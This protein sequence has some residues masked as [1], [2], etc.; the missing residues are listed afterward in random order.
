VCHCRE[1]LQGHIRHGG[2]CH[3]AAQK[4]YWARHACLQVQSPTV[5]CH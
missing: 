3:V 4:L 2:A 1:G 5:A